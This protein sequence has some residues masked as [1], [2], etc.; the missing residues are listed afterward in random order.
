MSLSR[1]RFLH[2]V[3]LGTAS[4]LALPPLIQQRMLAFGSPSGGAVR[5]RGRVVLEKKGLARVAVS[6]GRT[7]ATTDKQGYFDLVADAESRFV[8]VS[9]PAGTK[10]PTLQAGTA[11]L[12]Q[13]IRA[14]SRGEMQASFTLARLDER[15]SN[16]A[17]VVMADPQTQNRKETDLM[18]AETVPALIQLKSEIGD[19]PLHGIGCGDLMF[20]DLTLYPEYERVA[21]R[22]G[23][24]FFQVV[25]NHDMNYSART[26]EASTETWERHFGPSW[27]SFNR[28]EVHYVVLDDVFW[29][30]DGYIGYIPARQLAWLEQDLAQVAPG[31][32]VV[33]SLHIPA[34]STRPERTN[35][36]NG[37]ITERVTNR[38]GLYRL[39]EPFTA[40]I[41]SG[42]THENEHIFSGKVHEQVHGTACGAWWSGP[43]C[44]DGTPNGFSLYEARGSELRWSYRGSGLKPD[45]QVRAYAAGSDKQAADAIVANVWNWDPAWKVV[46]YEGADRRGPMMRRRGLDPLSVTLHGGPKLP[47]GRDWVDPTPT[48]HLFYA[49]A[50]AAGMPVR[51][52]VTD[53]FGRVYSAG[54]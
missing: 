34:A 53:R 30:G 16:H 5:V 14:D 18:H 42:H 25:G 33:V 45:D 49:P 39:L 24:P 37:R 43:I 11:N 38:E 54:V 27:Y 10:V 48:D 20:D 1:R 32:T 28:G 2:E 17:F 35:S 47:V 29:H 41:M 19:V 52:E 6:D 8:H 36:G 7:V 26:D 22:T 46:W 3:S 4:A 9:L 40:H 50:P 12:F 15:D 51:V 23:I 44:W 21:T 13:P 31:S